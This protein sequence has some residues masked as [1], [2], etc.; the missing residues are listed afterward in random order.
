MFKG[1]QIIC[2]VGDVDCLFMEV[3]CLGL[4]VKSINVFLL[5]SFLNL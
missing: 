2:L 4:C 3:C 1:N 5:S